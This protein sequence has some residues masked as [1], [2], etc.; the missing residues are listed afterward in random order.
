MSK[1]YQLALRE[2]VSDTAI[3][4]VINLPLNMVFL[5]IAHLIGLSII[6]TSVFMT[7][8]F[9]VLAVVRKTFVRVYYMR[10]Q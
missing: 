3:A 6:A 8:S 2:A 7:V 9:T 1:E 5:Y 4:F 10:K